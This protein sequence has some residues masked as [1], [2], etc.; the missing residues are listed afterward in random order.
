MGRGAVLGASVA[1]ALT[2]APASAPEPCK[3]RGCW[4][5]ASVE[6]RPRHAPC[7]GALACDLPYSAAA[8]AVQ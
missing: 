3:L 2:A 5:H 7:N 1:A 8:T 6:V 4:R